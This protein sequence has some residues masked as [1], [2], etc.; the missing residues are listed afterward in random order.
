P[1]THPGRWLVEPAPL[2]TVDAGGP[3][4][5][6][7]VP[8]RRL[9]GPGWGEQSEN[10]ARGD[11]RPTLLPCGPVGHTPLVRLK[12]LIWSAFPFAGG[13]LS[14]QKRVRVNRKITSS[15]AMG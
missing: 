9:P 6:R 11:Q 4:Q 1:Q 7:L 8:P 13:K 5:R 2:Q 12:R 3:C 15:F 10:R 14:R